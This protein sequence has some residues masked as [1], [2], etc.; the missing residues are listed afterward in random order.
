ML[1][2]IRSARDGL[3]KSEQKVADV[4]LEDPDGSVQ[5][6]IQTIAAK[7]AVSEPTVI[8]FCRALDCVGFQQFKLRLA[9][10]LASRGTFFYE[11]VTAS[12]SSKELSSK[13]IDGTIASI[14]Q[15]KNQ[16][17]DAAL[18]NAI[19]LYDECER[20]EFHGS[21]GSAIVAEDAQLKYFRLGKPAIAYNDPHIQQAAAALYNDK[22]LM[23][24]ISHSGRSSDILTA[25]EIAK[26]ARAKVLSVT[27]TKSPL[28]EASDVHLS[29]DLIEDS[30]I[31][32]PVKSR[33]GQMLILDILSVGIAV[34]GGDEILQQ[35]ARARRA[36]DSRFVKPG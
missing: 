23:V 1:A 14:M 34:R 21:G 33:M 18:D 2:K 20:I 9:Q 16:F 19:R 36:I 15:M 12:D 28:A 35:L 30:D 3:R 27:A 31:F 26:K 13:I 10:D 29:V 7:A 8:R 6:S 5:S 11:D 22:T 4:V 17:N 24:A 32:S 25:V